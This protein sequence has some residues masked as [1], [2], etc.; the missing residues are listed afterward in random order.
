MPAFYK[1]VGV[2]PWQVAHMLTKIQ[3]IIGIELPLFFEDLG[4]HILPDSGE[5]VIENAFPEL[6]TKL[7]WQRVSPEYFTFGL[8]TER[9][10]P[11][12]LQWYQREER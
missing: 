9:P 3:E 11:P 5:V 10:V 8:Q 4:P 12:V 2:Q 6:T 1:L 7:T